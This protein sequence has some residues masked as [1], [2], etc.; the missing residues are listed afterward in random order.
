MIS[1]FKKILATLVAECRSRGIYYSLIMNISQ[2]IGVLRGAVYKLIYFKNIRSSIFSLQAN[3]SI[4]VFNKRSKIYIGPFVFIRKNVS[5]R[6]DYNGELHIEEKVFIND[7]CN[8]NCVNR[9]S[10]GGN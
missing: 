9:I 2:I 10:I 7:N 8:I 1:I 5:I 6:V 3:S 4:E